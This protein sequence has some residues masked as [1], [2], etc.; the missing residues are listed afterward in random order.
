MFFR[1]LSALTLCLGLSVAPVQ[2]ASTTTSSLAVVVEGSPGTYSYSIGGWA[3]GG[4]VSGTFSGVDT[5]LNGQLSSFSG[6]VTGF[7]MSYSGGTLVGSLG[8]SFAELFGLV[9]DLDAGPLGDGT[10]LAIEGIGANGAA[11]SFLFGPGPMNLCGGSRGEICGLIN[12]PIGPNGVPE[13][14]S[15]ALFGLALAGLAMQRRKRS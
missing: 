11:G 10:S 1:T 4:V 6:E 9:Y 2:A 3:G 8:F 5:D 7:S 15:L 12:S 14:A 13:P